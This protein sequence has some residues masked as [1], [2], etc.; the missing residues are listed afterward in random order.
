MTTWIA[1]FPQGQRGCRASALR[2]A[3]L[4][5]LITATGRM[6]WGQSQ[7]SGKDWPQFL[8]PQRN[9]ISDE[10]GL[11]DSWPDGGPKK[12]WRVPGGV[13]MS[14]IVVSRGRMVTLLQKDGEQR[15]VSLA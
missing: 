13:G 5:C 8:G 3:I 4:C 10:T 9:G 1:L 7:Q 12:L 15:L 2:L 11:L 6:G 14:G